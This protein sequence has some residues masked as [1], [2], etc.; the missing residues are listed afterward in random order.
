VR[1]QGVVLED[2]SHTPLLRGNI[3]D[4]ASAEQDSAANGRYWARTSDQLVDTM[5]AFVSAFRPF[6]VFMGM[7]AK[8][9]QHP[10]L[11]DASAL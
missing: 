7:L 3:G 5:R 8:W 2:H 4:V 10:A 6:R 11:G 9:L 1:E